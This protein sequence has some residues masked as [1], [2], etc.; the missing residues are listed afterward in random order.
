ME[1]GDEIFEKFGHNAL[2]VTDAATGTDAL[3]NY[4]VFTFENNFFYR[5][6]KGDRGLLGR[7]L[8]AQRKRSTATQPT[9]VPSGRRS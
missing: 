5:F 9:T 4:G 6:L 8:A 1:P 7:S 3:F 2:R